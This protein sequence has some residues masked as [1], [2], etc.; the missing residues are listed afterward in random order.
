VPRR[1]PPHLARKLVGIIRKAQKA[2]PPAYPVRQSSGQRPDDDTIARYEALRQWR[3][4]KAAE[5]GVDA[6]VVMTNNTLM[7]IARANPGSQDELETLG[8]LGPWKSR[9]YGDELLATLRR[10]D[11]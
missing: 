4:Q 3:T 11:S 6:D 8:I 9:A 1:F 7:A 5:R 10:S 2:P